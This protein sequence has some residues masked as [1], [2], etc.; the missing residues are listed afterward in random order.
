MKVGRV[1]SRPFHVKMSEIVQTEKIKALRDIS[2]QDLR[3]AEM[4][5]MYYQVPIIKA[6]LLSEQYE[7]LS[8]E[9]KNADMAL[10]PHPFV[11]T[12][13]GET[14]VL[15]DCYSQKLADLILMQNAGGA[16][17]VMDL[18]KNHLKIG[19]DFIGGRNGPGGVNHV[20]LQIK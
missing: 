18:I 1:D 4:N 17:E 2:Q 12:K 16:D 9:I 6:R 19:N 3:I 20:H 11:N 7:V 5:F 10:I 14:V 8:Q 15:V 13:P